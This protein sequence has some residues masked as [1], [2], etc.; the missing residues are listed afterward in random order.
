MIAAYITT[1]AHTARC[2]PPISMV[3]PKI[4]EVVILPAH[5]TLQDAQALPV[6]ETLLLFLQT[7]TLTK[8]VTLLI[9]STWVCVEPPG[10]QHMNVSSV[11]SPPFSPAEGQANTPMHKPRPT[12]HRP[13]ALL[14]P[15]RRLS[16]SSRHL[17]RIH[18]LSVV[19]LCAS[20]TTHFCLPV[21]PPVRGEYLYLYSPWLAVLEV[22]I[23]VANHNPT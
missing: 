11:F 21:L 3:S 9:S 1:D 4:A 10:F 14:L 16:H 6:Q 15:L 22:F 20:V 8:R 23:S 19:V 18:P 13:A 5:H 7:I 2:K 17:P 12:T